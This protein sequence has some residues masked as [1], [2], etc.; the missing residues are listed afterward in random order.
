MGL[1]PCGA[2]K[3]NINIVIIFQPNLCLAPSGAITMR[4]KPNLTLSKIS[5]KQEKIKNKGGKVFICVPRA[6]YEI[7]PK[8]HMI[9]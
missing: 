5:I 3:F 2:K 8:N 6:V 1:L 9:P 7:P 4:G